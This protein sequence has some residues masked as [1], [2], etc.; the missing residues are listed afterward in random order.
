MTVHDSNNTSSMSV[1]ISEGLSRDIGSSCPLGN[2]PGNH[3]CP[4]CHEQSLAK[5]QEEH[6]SGVGYSHDVRQ[7]VEVVIQF[8]MH[9]ELLHLSLISCE[10]VGG[11][12]EEF[13]PTMPSSGS[14]WG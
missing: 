4:H 7:V 3:R 13:V 11:L 5:G 2:V 14:S 12:S 6:A 10:Y 8:P 9:E 1:I